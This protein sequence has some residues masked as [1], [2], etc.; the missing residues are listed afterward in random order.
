[1]ARPVLGMRQIQRLEAGWRGF[2]LDKLPQA[3]RRL[4]L[5]ARAGG[6]RTGGRRGVQGTGPPHRGAR[7]GWSGSHKKLRPTEAT[8]FFIITFP[9]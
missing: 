1:M 9:I 8:I 6:R 3:R 2:M 7:A 4:R 5:R